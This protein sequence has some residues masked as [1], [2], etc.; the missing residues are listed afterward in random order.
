MLLRRLP[1]GAA[2]APP[3]LAGGREAR[4]RRGKE[5]G[6]WRGR[7]DRSLGLTLSQAGDRPR[8]RL[9]CGRAVFTRLIGHPDFLFSS[10][11]AV[12][13]WCAMG[14]LGDGAFGPGRCVPGGGEVSAL[15]S[16]R[17]TTLSVPVYISFVAFLV[18]TP[19]RVA[20][21][22]R[23]G[24]VGLFADSFIVLLQVWGMKTPHL[25]TLCC[26]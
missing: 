8:P 16:Q 2:W 6:G 26:S 25:C 23:F 20:L 10:P 11:E 3:V 7:K 24:E 5:D 19:H 15:H 1:C 12:G 18:D 21:E 14:T 13:A 9:L 22:C 4:P 17:C